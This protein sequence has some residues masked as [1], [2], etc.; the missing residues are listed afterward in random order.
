MDEIYK[1]HFIH[2]VGRPVP[3]TGEWK[4][5]VEVRWKEGNNELMKTLME[6]HFKRSFT[7]KTIAE[8]AG[9]LLAKKWID[10]GKP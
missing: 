6:S 3:N 4:P 9:L 5:T 1:G 7:T 8:T 2:A 10:D